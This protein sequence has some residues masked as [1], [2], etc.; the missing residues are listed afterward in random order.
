M[1]ETVSDVFYLT[2]IDVVMLQY[3]DRYLMTKI[4]Y[5]AKLHAFL[6]PYA[7]LTPQCRRFTL[8]YAS[9]FTTHD[10]SY[11]KLFHGSLYRGK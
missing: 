9:I 8:R 5:F 4:C 1:G 6:I 2:L 7:S 3:L 10:Y 11:I